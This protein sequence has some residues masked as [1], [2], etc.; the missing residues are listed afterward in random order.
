M[1]TSRLISRRR[2]DQGSK[3]ARVAMAI[4]ATVGAID[5]G[6]IT[7]HR[8]G[9]WGPLTCPGGSSGCDKVL[10]SPWGTIL[11]QNGFSIPLSFIGLLAYLA[12][13]VMAIIPLLPGLSENKVDLSRRTWWGLF[14]ASSAMAAFSSLLMGLMIF[15]IEAFCLFCVL[16]ATISIILLL[17]SL[18]GG[19]WDDFGELMFRGV[20]LSIFVLL[21]GLIWAS[22]VDPNRAESFSLDQG[23]PPLVQSVS[24]KA[25]IALAKHLSQSGAVM[26]SAYWCPHCHDQKEL[27][28]K[29]AVAELRIVECAEDG[30][31]NQRSLCQLKGIESYPTWEINGGFESGVK[32]L[33]NLADLT[34]YKGIRDF[35]D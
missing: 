7:L 33:D 30:Q 25:N 32:S 35:S 13:L 1:G 19:G 14:A 16:S 10:N 3:W 17:L 15:K 20:L 12:V 4:L 24:S 21:G 11:Q 26:Y 2:Q 28:G 31:N 34:G 9:W 22:S 8:W 6:S 27:F 18:I 23:V 5:T 29:N